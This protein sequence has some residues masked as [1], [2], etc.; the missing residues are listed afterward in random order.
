MGTIRAIITRPLGLGGAQIFFE[1]SSRLSLSLTPR[2]LSTKER[3]LPRA[4]PRSRQDLT[5]F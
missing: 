5:A 2:F 4:R 3:S 1:R